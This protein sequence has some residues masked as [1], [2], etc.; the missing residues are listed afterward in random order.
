MSFEGITID[1]VLSH[2]VCD[3]RL[4][5]MQLRLG[6]RISV[7]R[8]SVRR[9]YYSGLEIYMSRQ[10]TIGPPAWKSGGSAKFLV[11]RM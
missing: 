4:G 6:R 8:T 2:V 9:E 3:A 11:V 5:A 7:R 10:W 1:F